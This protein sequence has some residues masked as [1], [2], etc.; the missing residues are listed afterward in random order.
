[1]LALPAPL[2]YDTAYALMVK[3]VC[4]TKEEHEAMEKVE[5]RI[6]QYMKQQETGL[7]AIASLIPPADSK[8]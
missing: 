3:F 8:G 2:L 1:M 4:M 6:I 7:P 5:G